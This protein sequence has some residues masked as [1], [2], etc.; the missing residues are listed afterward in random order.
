MI[1]RESPADPAREH[2]QALIQQARAGARPTETLVPKPV[3]VPLWIGPYRILGTLGCGGM[4]VVY[5]AE[6]QNPR[7][8][9]ALKVLRHDFS[10]PD[11]EVRF[12]QREVQSLARLK[13][14]AIAAIYE[15]GVTPDGEHYFAMELVRGERLTD[16]V[17]QR[18][19]VTRDRLQLFHRICDAIGYAHQRGVVHRDLKPSNI[20][21][22][23]EGNPKILDFGLARL[24]EADLSLT[25]VSTEMGAL[26]GTLPYMSPEQAR[27]NPEDIDFRTDI[28]S[29]GVILYELITG[30]LPYNVNRALIFEAVRVI[31][32]EPPKKPSTINRTL[33]GDV[34]TIALK[35]L[36]KEPRRR[37]QT[38]AAL[39]D[40]I[41]RY[42]TD[43]PILARRP[44]AAY[45][46]KKL[47]LRHKVPFAFLGALFVLITAS[48]IWTQILYARARTN[49]ARAIEAEKA[50]QAQAEQA[51]V[52][53]S[54]SER[55]TEFLVD[56]FEVSDPNK[57]KGD[58]VTAREILDR[59]AET[60]SRELL[61]QPAI[62]SKLMDTMARV[63]VK[64]GLSD[65][66]RPLCERA[67][68]IRRTH[69]GAHHP[70]VADSLTTL[71][72]IFYIAGDF[73]NAIETA[74]EALTLRQKSLGEDAPGTAQSLNALGL[75]LLS[76]RNYA[77]AEPL[78]RRAIEIRK[79][80]EVGESGELAI[81]MNNLGLVLRYTGRLDEAKSMFTEALRIGR[82]MLGAKDMDLAVWLSNL[83]SIHQDQG[84][85][86]VAESM[87]EESLRMFR[88][89]AGKDHPS[90][91]TLVNNIGL[92]K[93][94]K[95]DFAGAEPMLREAM[96]GVATIIGTAH[97][98]YAT[99]QR[100]LGRALSA[101]GRWEEA[102]GLLR[103]SLDVLRSAFGST[104]A[105][106]GDGLTYLGENKLKMGDAI[107]AERL[108]REAVAILSAAGPSAASRLA[109][110]EGALGACLVSL[111]QYVEAEKLL[112]RSQSF[113]IMQSSVS[114][115][116][117]RRAIERLIDLYVAT[118]RLDE[119]EKFRLALESLKAGTSA[120]GS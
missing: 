112:L 2:E 93:F 20:L 92:L 23:E 52:E 40:D 99:V 84:N 49:L 62:R 71:G 21:V 102:D 67:L 27:A 59:G 55:V 11:R 17:A 98:N 107:E 87:F 63:F 100:N 113:V 8:V 96:A 50:A 33:R 76:N 16:Y 44:S 105:F 30:E 29:L 34:E 41:E 95:G 116:K 26:F 5:E 90:V 47:V 64:L 35:A 57:S 12:F 81:A 19:P 119:A 75:Y 7:R 106:V 68:E 18:N 60:V 9:V 3:S 79:K 73:T 14:A 69:F 53:A 37:Y 74:R 22:D 117:K 54:T 61:D 56:L 88:D 51:R 66:A 42:L 111:R 39:A 114:N 65:R 32:E 77:D 85:F 15:S 25:S 83:A 28:Y 101:L 1:P 104:H 97:P 43:Q 109:D 120:T 103:S 94:E 78:L 70:A 13:H 58:T 118:D 6:Q 91:V 72:S 10:R 31:C 38:A 89:L 4:G 46:F 45:Q 80:N 48:G 115:T 110:A 108:L 36:E 86:A 24:T 82:T